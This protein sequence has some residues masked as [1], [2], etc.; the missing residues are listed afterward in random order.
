MAVRR[1]LI[2]T[3]T[4]NLIEMTD[5]QRNAVKDRC[6]FLYGS[7]PSVTL[8]VVG[9]G[10]N[11]G[12]ISD[13]R[14][15]AG[16][17]TTRV[18]RFSTAG[19]TPNISTVTVNYARV[20]Q[21]NVNTTASVDTNNIAFPIYYN[22]N[23]IQ[24]MSLQ[25]M[26]DTFIFDAIDTLLSA[27]GQ[28]GTYRVHTS[29]SLSGYSLVSSTPIFS[30]TR[31]N[32]SA[33]TAGG[34]G[35]TQDQPTTITNFYLLQAN[36]ISAPTMEEML[37]VRNSDKNLQE[38]SQTSIDAILENCIR[39]VASEETGSQIRYQFGGSGVTLGSGITNT[40]LNGSGNYQTRF[41]N[42]DDYRTQEFPNGSP[43]TANT[44]FLKMYEA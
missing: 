27:V 6:R 13:T 25:D 44:Y 38:Y 11:L 2:L 21:S 37:F 34:I 4:N 15:Q 24:T 43:V 29:T 36:N 9:S 31:A 22:G 40:I 39:H 3:G 26:Y 42:T 19:E 35:E 5:A 28:P 14:K 8:S 16:A 41:V 17:S 23:N 10:G 18:D 12:S 33:Y 30:D 7:N 20:S 32:V 1:P